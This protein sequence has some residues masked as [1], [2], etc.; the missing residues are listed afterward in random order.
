MLYFIL[1]HNLADS[2]S[3][4]QSINKYTMHGFNVMSEN[5]TQLNLLWFYFTLKPCYWRFNASKCQFSI[6]SFPSSVFHHP[7]SILSFPSSVFHHQFSIISFPSSVF[8][9]QFSII[10]FPSSVFHPQFSI[11]SFPS[12]VFHHPFSIISFPSSVF[13]H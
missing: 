8:H 12:S 13:H 9:P 2:Q 1:M 11:L 3:I 7:F 5:K 6:I 10:R 4:N